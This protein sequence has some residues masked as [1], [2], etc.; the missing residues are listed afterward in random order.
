MTNRAEAKIYVTTE[1]DTAEG[2]RKISVNLSNVFQ[3]IDK[4][5]SD[6]NN[7]QQKSTKSTKD[8]SNSFATMGKTIAVVAVG[9]GTIWAGFKVG[10]AALG[11]IVS[12]ASKLKDTTYDLYKNGLDEAMDLETAKNGLAGIISSVY[13]IKKDGIELVGGDKFIAATTEAE[14]AVKRLQVAAAQSGAS[15]KELLDAFNSGV[16]NGAGLGLTISQVEKFAV[17]V[18]NAAKA[19]GVQEGGMAQE[20]NALLTG[21]VT[22]DAKIASSLGV[23][24]SGKNRQAYLTALKKGGDEA[25]KYLMGLMASFGFAIERQANSL[26]GIFD[27]F[28]DGAKNLSAEIASGLSKELL[29]LKPIIESVFDKNTNTLTKD[30][31]GLKATL[32]TIGSL[33][34]K[35]IVEA[36]KMAYQWLAGISKLL[37]ENPELLDKLIFQLKKSWLQFQLAVIDTITVLAKVYDQVKKIVDYFNQT[38]DYNDV[39]DSVKNGG[40]VSSDMILEIALKGRVTNKKETEKAMEKSA[41]AYTNFARK[42]I[43]D[44]LDNLKI[45]DTVSKSV[46]E[47]VKKIDEQTKAIEAAA[48]GTAS[49]GITL[50]ADKR[51]NTDENKKNLDKMLDLQ[52]IFFDKTKHNIDLESKYNELN[53]NNRFKT[54]E[55]FYSS[56][57]DLMKKDFNNEMSY[58]DSQITAIQ[59]LI[60]DKKLLTQDDRDSK[61]KQLNELLN[62]RN[63]LESEYAFKIK[64]SY[65]QRIKEINEL[66]KS[67]KQFKASIDEMLGLTKQA[68]VIRLSIEIDGLNKNFANDEEML[69]LIEQ[70]KELKLL[71]IETSDITSVLDNKE[72]NLNKARDSNK[73]DLLSY[74]EEMNSLIQQRIDLYQKE[75]DLLTSSGANESNS[76]RVR[77]LKTSIDDLKN[78]TRNFSDD[79]KE[80]WRGEFD[81]FFTSVI[82]G[83]KSVKDAF[84]DMINNITNYITKFAAQ[85]LMDQLFNTGESTGKS[86]GFGGLID[87]AAGWVSGLFSGGARATG[88]FVD[89]GKPY[90]VGEG[91]R[92]EIFVPNTSGYVMNASRSND[93]MN[94]GGSNGTVNNYYNIYANNPKEF[95]NSKSQ[96][97]SAGYQAASVANRR[98]N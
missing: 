45:D 21:E 61:E 26:A 44:S 37:L 80:N 19:T 77:Q 27:A 91:G 30:F 70:Y 17:V 24:P 81:T 74:Y 39:V 18:A 12:L 32:Q 55:E 13:K 8:M 76:E 97:L 42:T 10:Q 88:G 60:S 50:G 92:P 86:G 9:F 96:I 83:T 73:T 16:G 93:L 33:L 48:N 23:G 63:M 4:S 49:S 7:N 52:K 35:V 94:N 90:L 3:N 78:S 69:G 28:K 22:N 65:Y 57:E 71:Q 85:G 53:Y 11:G 38:S 40:D 95:E 66:Q 43:Q 79:L 25:Y 2:L 62:Q 89:A 31:D 41:E 87:S 29:N 20:L 15:F 54:A 75:L 1:D 34:G 67:T 59:G 98:N 14:A 51:V 68:S 72:Q 47:N 82:D 36:A 6:I 84:R 64:D 46:R 56:K 5:L 58:I